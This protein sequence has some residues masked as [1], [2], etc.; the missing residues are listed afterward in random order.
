MHVLY[1]NA[2]PTVQKYRTVQSAYNSYFVPSLCYKEKI[3]IYTEEKHINIYFPFYKINL[4]NIFNI[5]I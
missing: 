3:Y 4:L 1:S 2:L 5:P